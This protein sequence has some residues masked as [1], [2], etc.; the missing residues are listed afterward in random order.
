MPAQRA[1]IFRDALK[2]S[3]VKEVRAGARRVQSGGTFR[4][5]SLEYS[6]TNASFIA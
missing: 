2:T 5:A 4:D 1:P 6:H 3:S